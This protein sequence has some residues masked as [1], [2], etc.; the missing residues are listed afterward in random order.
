M[1]SELFSVFRELPSSAVVRMLPPIMVPR[2]PA[3]IAGLRAVY[4][5]N[6]L[7]IV[8][9]GI[10]GGSDG[11]GQNHATLTNFTK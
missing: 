11:L 10:E 5:D 4:R 2:Q 9:D 6:R 1:L 3:I 7:D 8:S